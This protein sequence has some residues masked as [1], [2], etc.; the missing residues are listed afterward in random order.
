MSWLQ[1]CQ[2]NNWSSLKPGQ[3]F[4]GQLVFVFVL[5]YVPYVLF[6]LFG[7]FVVYSLVK[8]DYYD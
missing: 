5:C 6:C 7:C 2:N 4:L 1:K 8:Q 3:P